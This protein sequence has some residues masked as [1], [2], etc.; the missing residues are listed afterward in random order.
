[1]GFAQDA[2]AMSLRGLWH[3]VGMRRPLRSLPIQTTLRFHE[4]QD[5]LSPF[6]QTSYQSYPQVEL[7]ASGS[8]LI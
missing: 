5:L 1:M 2:P 3:G 6:S 4:K 8:P 7:K